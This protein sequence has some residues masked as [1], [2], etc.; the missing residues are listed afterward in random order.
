MIWVFGFGPDDVYAVGVAGGFIRY[1]GV[2]WT[3][4]ETGQNDKNLWGIWGQSPDDMWIVGGNA[5]SGS[6]L[7]L[8]YNGQTLT[9]YDVSTTP[10]IFTLFK[11]W[12]AGSRVF[13]VGQSGV[14][15]EFNGTAWQ[16]MDSGGATDQFI[17][18]WG[19]GEDNIVAV[20]GLVQPQVAH[21]DGSTW[22][23]TV[24]NT[25]FFGLN[26]VYM[27]HPDQAIIGGA[28]GFRGRFDVTSSMIT[29]EEVTFSPQVHAIWSDCNG[30]FYAVG[31][32]FTGAY[33]GFY[34]VRE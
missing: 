17:S 22:T 11:V 8:R 18:L 15:V 2:Q 21:F 32:E 34:V 23:T 24:D 7:I 26:A 10:Q 12:G 19:T 27:T 30:R 13:A 4:I 3:S 5:F 1:D 28:N 16:Q 25:S 20:G 6:P 33:N 9:P 29:T 14:I 31:G